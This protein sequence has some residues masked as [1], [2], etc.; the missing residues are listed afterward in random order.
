MVMAVFP[1][2]V[3]AAHRAYF[4][5]NRNNNEV[6]FHY[7]LTIAVCFMAGGDGFGFG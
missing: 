5:N 7:C 1:A 3:N 4:V 6:I 2:L